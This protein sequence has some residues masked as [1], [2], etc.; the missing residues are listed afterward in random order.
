VSLSTWE[1]I[2]GVVEVSLAKKEH[3]EWPFAVKPSKETKANSRARPYKKHSGEVKSN[4]VVGRDND[5]RRIENKSKSKDSKSWAS[6]KYKYAPKRIADDSKDA[7]SSGARKPTSSS[8]SSKWD[9]FDADQA[10][11]DL[12][13]EDNPENHSWRVSKDPGVATVDCVGY[14]KSKEE[15]ALDTDLAAG[16]KRMKS[17]LRIRLANAQQCKQNGNDLV[18]SKNWAEALRFYEDGSE[19]LGVA[20]AAAPLMSESLGK[21]VRELSTALINNASLCHLK[22]G[23]YKAAHECSKEV[24]KEDSANIKALCRNAAALIE[25]GKDQLAKTALDKV[26]KLSPSSKQVAQL[27]A[28]L[29]EKKKIEG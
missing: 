8:S 22:L 10:L 7:A 3:R 16:V 6:E 2:D 11:A 19:Q 18:K 9:K 28:R 17:M 4:P 26:Q 12:E 14:Q 20:K 23:Q 5:T 13:N 24:L 1:L 27:M 15:V 29:E 21:R 25:L